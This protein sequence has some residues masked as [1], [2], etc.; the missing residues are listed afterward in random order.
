MFKTQKEYNELASQCFQKLL[1]GD[2]Y[3]SLAQM[4]T[5]SDIY[6]SENEANRTLATC[7]KLLGHNAI[8]GYRLGNRL[9]DI[10]VNETIIEGKLEPQSV[11]VDR[12]IGQ[13]TDFLHMSD[14]HIYIVLYGDTKEEIITRIKEQLENKYL[15]RIS[16]VYLKYPTRRKKEIPFEDRNLLNNDFIKG[17]GD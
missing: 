8:Y 16:L 13:I 14:Y 9:I 10:F 6:N 3:K 5:I 7:L 2:I 11:E 12:L 17:Y 1:I 4:D 15:D